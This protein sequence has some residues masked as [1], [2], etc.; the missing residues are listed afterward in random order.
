MNIAMT[1]P[2]SHGRASRADFADPLSR[3]HPAHHPQ[4]H[5]QDRATDHRQRQ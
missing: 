2:T 5:D 3:K 4:I 1:L